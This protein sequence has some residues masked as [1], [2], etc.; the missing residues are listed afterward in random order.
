MSAERL[1]ALQ[2][3]HAFDPFPVRE[4]LG[5]YHVPFGRL[6][7]TNHAEETLL[8]ACRRSERVAIVGDSGTG[9]SS[10][11]ASVLGPLAE[12]VA[13]V[14]VPVAVEPTDAPFRGDHRRRH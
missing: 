12:G 14:L 5:I 4:D 10:L 7:G 8:D 13:P 2:E 3:A 11:T 6:V 9:K 1:V